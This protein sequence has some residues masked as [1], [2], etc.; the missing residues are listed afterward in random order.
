MPPIMRPPKN[1][2]SAR[3]GIP[4]LIHSIALHVSTQRL[5]DGREHIF[6]HTGPVFVLAGRI[7]LLGIGQDDFG[8]YIR[9]MFLRAVDRPKSQEIV[10]ML[11]TETAKSIPIASKTML[12][13]EDLEIILRERYPTDDEYGEFVIKILRNESKNSEFML[14]GWGRE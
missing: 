2:T 12:V 3:A 8:V 10:G 7:Y 1:P 6:K 14:Y 4:P 13:H 11:L 9:P 5:D